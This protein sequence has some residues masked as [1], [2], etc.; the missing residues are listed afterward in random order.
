MVGDT[1]K[2][3]FPFPIYQKMPP[4]GASSPVAIRLFLTINTSG[5]LRTLDPFCFATG[6][7]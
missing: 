5:G 3:V 7:R 2:V 1:S 4:K 6:Q